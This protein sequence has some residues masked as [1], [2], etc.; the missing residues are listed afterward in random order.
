MR[1]PYSDEDIETKNYTIVPPVGG[2]GIG[3]YFRTKD[4]EKAE[5][6]E[7]FFRRYKMIDIEVEDLEVVDALYAEGYDVSDYFD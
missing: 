4:G 1:K 2:S 6:F 7:V 3:S 5:G